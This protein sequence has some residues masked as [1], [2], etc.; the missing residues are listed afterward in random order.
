MNGTLQHSA[1]TETLHTMLPRACSPLSLGQHGEES[2]RQK[3]VMIMDWEENNLLE[4]A[5]QQK[6]EL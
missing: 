5:M 4:T 3:K 6:N 1:P 2:W